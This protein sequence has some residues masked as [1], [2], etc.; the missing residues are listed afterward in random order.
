LALST[1][2]LAAVT[3]CAVSLLGTTAVAQDNGVTF[4]VSQTLE[5]SDNIDFNAAENEGFRSSTALTFGYVTKTRVDS[6]SLSASTT[7]QL[8]TDAGA[9]NAFTEPLLRLAYERNVKNA[10]INVNLSYRQAEISS[11]IATEELMDAGFIQID[12]GLQTDIGYSFGVE[13][14]RTDPV[15][16]TIRYSGS[17][18]RYTETDDPAMMDRDNETLSA[19]LNFRIDPRITARATAS[20]SR[21]EELNDGIARDSTQLGLGVDFAV[22]K[23]LQVSTSLN[24]NE[25][26]RTEAGVTTTSDGLGFSVS[27]T[28]ETP[29]GPLT[30]TLSSQ[31]NE[32][33]RRTS[34]TASRSLEL[35]NGSLSFSVGG[36]QGEDDTFDPQYSLNYAQELPR[37]AAISFRASQSFETSSTGDEAIN[38]QLAAQYSRPLTE[39]SR[40]SA[41]ANYR[42]TNGI[43]ANVDDASRMDLGLQYQ[44]DLVQ[45]WGL[46]GGYRRSFA[47]ETGEPDRTSNTVFVGLEKTFAWRP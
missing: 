43:G 46:I 23:T 12:N 10:G 45:D 7:A 5:Y 21:F 8:G 15:G 39:V 18:R 9:D 4:G 42:E 35:R 14:G 37:G 28:Q 41:S 30:A 34:I 33:G 19:Q 11:I 26:E 20:Q 3:Y 22:T 13:F 44:H 25:V 40:L 47:S 27:A 36:S 31:V 38:T 6:L 1:K 24:Y 32:N 16:G 2:N 17:T 29:T